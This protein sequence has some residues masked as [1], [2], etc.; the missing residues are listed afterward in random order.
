M[1][2][3][4]GNYM[5]G[6]NLIT[7][8]SCCGGEIPVEVKWDIKRTLMTTDFTAAEVEFRKEEKTREIPFETM[9]ELVFGA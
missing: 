3:T 1:C 6:N 4:C 2:E 7:M 9:Q 5:G 8:C